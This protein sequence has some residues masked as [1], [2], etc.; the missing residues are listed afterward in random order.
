ML[1][2]LTLNN[3]CWVITLERTK[4]HKVAFSLIFHYSMRIPHEK[5]KQ[6]VNICDIIAEKLNKKLTFPVKIWRLR[7]IFWYKN[8]NVG[9]V[10]L[11]KQRF[12]PQ[13]HKTNAP[14]FPLNA[15]RI[16]IKASGLASLYYA[17]I[18]PQF[19]WKFAI[20]IFIAPV[21]MCFLV[22]LS[23]HLKLI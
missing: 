14:N 8:W 16:K 23:A 2:L 10:H 22:I 7:S 18:Y 5:C 20:F 15:F 12:F 21:R 9:N 19:N 6:F 17:W 1:L 13:L 4:K 3:V 11:Q